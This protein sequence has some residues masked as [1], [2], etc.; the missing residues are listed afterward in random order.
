MIDHGCK[1]SFG[2]GND[3][4]L[5]GDMILAHYLTCDTLEKGGGNIP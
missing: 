3:I 5:S 1:F 2:K 4:A